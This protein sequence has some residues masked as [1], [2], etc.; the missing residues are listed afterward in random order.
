MTR[1]ASGVRAKF[2]RWW[3]RKYGLGADDQ[4]LAWDPMLK[5]Y[6]DSNIHFEWNAFRAGYKAGRK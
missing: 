4:H 1:K 3:L 2:E 6:I 5:E